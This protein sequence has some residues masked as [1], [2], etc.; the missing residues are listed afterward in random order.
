[1]SNI[2]SPKFF[3]GQISRFDP[4]THL[5]HVDPHTSH[6]SGQTGLMQGIPLVSIFA[7]T[8]GFKESI[9]YPVGAQV[10]CMDA[11]GGLCYIIGMLPDH[12]HGDVSYWSRACLQ[13]EDTNSQDADCN[14]KGYRK[15]VANMVL[16]NNY[17]PTDVTEGEYVVSNELGVLIGLFQ[18]LA[19]LK[20]SELAQVQCFLLD[21]LVR[22]ISHNFSHWTSMGEV[23]IWHDGKTIT[24]EYGAT[25]LSRESMGIPQ[26]TDKSEPMF[27]EDGKG[28]VD[29]SSDYYKIKEDERAKAI[30]R[31]KMFV[32]RLG[33]FLHIYLCRPD[34]QAKRALNGEAGGDFDRGLFDVHVGTDGRVAVRTVTGLSIEKTSWIRVPLRVRTPE[35]PKGDEVAD[36]N[37]D[38]KTPFEWDNTYKVK[39]N[40][41]G[42]FLQLRDCL[43]YTQDRYAYLNFDKYKKDFQF[44]KDPSDKEKSLASCEDIDPNTKV[45]FGDYQLRHAG[46]YLMDNGGITIRDAW[47]SAIVMEGGNIYQQPVKDLIEQ[48][49]RHAITKAG[50]SIQQSAKKHIDIS[51]TEEGFRLKTNKVQ[52]FYS[53]EQGLI[54]QTDSTSKSAPTPNGEAYDTFGGILFHA[55]DSGIF[56]FASIIFDHSS[57]SSLYKATESLTMEA[58]DG[59]MWLIPDQSLYL[60]PKESA[61]MT[62]NGSI[63]IASEGT[64]MFGGGG[65]TMLGNVGQIVGMV[66]HPG[67]AFPAIMDGLVPVS[68]LTSGFASARSLQDDIVQQLMNPFD[69]EDKFTDIK[70]RFLA[71]DKFGLEEDEDFI[72]MTLG[73]QDDESFGFL[74]LVEWTEEEVESTLP[75]PGKDKFENYYLKSDTLQNV[76][77]SNEGDDYE[78]KSFESIQSTGAKLSKGSLNSYK[79]KE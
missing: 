37:F 72:P 39:E 41:I 4:A 55:K 14:T 1:M 76:K 64:A 54:F 44:S 26:T 58:E 75:F 36:I 28:S 43:A 79:V 18:Q 34:D 49:L 25:H 17:R 40:P 3:L 24:A 63:M 19:V 35:D 47:G 59:D 31:L 6:D 7:T 2:P 23:N 53:K 11:S 22:L 15:D 32:G 57:T 21:D 67:S 73:Q 45:N 13:T 42:Y 27:Q 8:L 66:P 29:D 20:G 10:L 65:S 60:M 38:D 51:S 68:A 5:V 74:N 12:D 56:S 71:S 48:P 52:H 16:M 30:E 33:D 69:T 61:I 70:F 9:T 78:S 50:H 46:I 62:T 77:K